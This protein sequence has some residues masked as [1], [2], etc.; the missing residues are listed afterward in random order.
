MF[1]FT[2]SVERESLKMELVAK[3]QEL[4]GQKRELEEKAAELSEALLVRN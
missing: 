1:Y 4:Y 2:F 3:N